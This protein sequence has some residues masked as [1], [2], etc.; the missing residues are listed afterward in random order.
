MSH[1]YR[2]LIHM[3]RRHNP[4]VIIALFTATPNRTDSLPLWLL[5][6]EVIG[7]MSTQDMISAGYLVPPVT[8]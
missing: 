1:S 6:D 2:R 8:M 5:V 3:L 4:K 7:N